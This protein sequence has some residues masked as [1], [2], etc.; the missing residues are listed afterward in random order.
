M[1]KKKYF[2][3]YCDV[4]ALGNL[5][6]CPGP[7]SAMADPARLCLQSWPQEEIAKSGLVEVR[8]GKQQTEQRFGFSLLGMGLSFQ[9][10]NTTDFCCTLLP[11]YLM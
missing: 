5:T 6:R 1:W 2:K 3:I 7:N 9:I 10:L 4:E 11:S 8:I